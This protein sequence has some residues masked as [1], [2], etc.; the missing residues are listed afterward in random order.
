MLGPMRKSLVIAVTGAS[1]VPYALRLLS[2][3]ERLK[4]H[5]DLLVSEAGAEVLRREVG[6]ERKWVE[7][8]LPILADFGLSGEFSRAFTLRDFG[9]P[10]AS[11]T[12]L[13]D[14]MI[15]IP[16]S[17]G[18]VGRLA[19]GI[20]SNLIERA[21]DVCLKE[22]RPLT[23]VCRETP[24]SSIHLRNMLTL[25]EAGAVVLPASPGFYNN[26]KTLDDLIDH[27][28]AKILSTVGID[29][30]LIKPWGSEQ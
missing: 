1:G 27:L 22:R 18:T 9:A 14:G 8:G 4:I 23:V 3:L 19:A 26:P 10:C 28:C 21:A 24:V 15:I 17:M 7:N 5:V 30:Q 20:S 13:G 11:G 25:S 2:H 6:G 16:A 12:G 29:H